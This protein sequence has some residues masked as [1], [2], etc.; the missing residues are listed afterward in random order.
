MVPE[1]PGLQFRKREQWFLSSVSRVILDRQNLGVIF[2]F[3]LTAGYVLLY[4]VDECIRSLIL[5]A[6]IIR[7][8]QFNPL[9]LIPR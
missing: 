5:V 8:Y 3:I 1:M 2:T 4:N 6:T 7:I 9:V